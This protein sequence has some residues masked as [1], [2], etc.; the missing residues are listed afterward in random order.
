MPT[1]RAPRARRT[2]PW[3]AASSATPPSNPLLDLQLAGLDHPALDRV[4]TLSLLTLLAVSRVAAFPSSIWDQD[5]AYF[6]ATVMPIATTLVPLLVLVLSFSNPEHLRY[7]LAPLALSV[8]L[9]VIALTSVARQWA[10]VIVAFAVIGGAI[11][12]LSALGAYRTQASPAV[13]ATRF[14]FDRARESGS[15][16]V[17]DRTLDAFVS[18]ERGLRPFHGTV[19]MDYQIDFGETV[20]PPEFATVYLHDRRNPSL[21]ERA[22]SCRR[23]ACS[24]P[25]LRRLEQGRFVELEVTTGTVLRQ[26]LERP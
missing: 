15:V 9:V 19:V 24:Q 23:F 7:W 14:A 18:L 21:L 10:Q 16:V 12:V 11:P 5:E 1:S 13:A 20:P 17:V 6:S 3:W 25:L 22:A 26:R 2:A 4:L 8:G